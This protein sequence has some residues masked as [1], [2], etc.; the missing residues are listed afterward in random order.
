M[1]KWARWS[2][3]RGHQARYFAAVLTV[4]LRDGGGGLWWWSGGVV[5]WEG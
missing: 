2:E 3:D 5:E 4:G 1:R